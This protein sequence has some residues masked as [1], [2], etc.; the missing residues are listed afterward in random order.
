[1]DTFFR[2]LLLQDYNTRLVV[3]GTVLL[4]IAAGTVGSLLLLRKRALIG[5]VIS[6]ATLPGVAIAFLL[7]IILGGTGRWPVGLL[8][9]AG[10]AGVA[11][12][13]VVLL[14]RRT[15]MLRDDAAMAIVMSTAF[16]VGIALLGVIQDLPTG[17]QAGLESIIYGKTATKVRADA[18]G[19]GLAALLVV[20]MAAALYKE[21][22]LL[23]F[24]AHFAGSQG[25]PVNTLD[26]ALLLLG[27]AV[28]VI[29]LQAVGLILVLALLIIPAAA[30]RYWTDRLV[31][32]MVISALLGAASAWIGVTISA[33]VPRM[34]AGAVI[35]LSAAGFF[36]VSLVFGSRC[37]L[38]L[39]FLRA[40]RIHRRTNRQHI[41][42]AI[43]ECQETSETVRVQDLIN[44][45]SWTRREVDRL[46]RKA[47]RRGEVSFH[48]DHVVILSD[49]GRAAAEVVVRNHRLWELFL[50]QHADIAP[51]HVDRDADAIEHVLGVELVRELEAAL[52]PDDLLPS[53][54]HGLSGGTS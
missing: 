37:G 44:R 30:A 24:D 29:G 40:L 25:W 47:R 6:H 45:R 2:V 50:I 17:N 12:A 21:F 9:G 32:M 42:R 14:L 13:A 18:I 48:G 1:M 7:M 11:A 38:L 22:R 35:V 41:L 26:I 15:T 5:D 3:I 52:G 43:W 23:C 16:G 39:R 51:T 53:S 49:H 8:V 28:T 46:L 54:P 36:V 27:T 10:V 19:I 20:L 31:Q 33:L 34:P 4:G